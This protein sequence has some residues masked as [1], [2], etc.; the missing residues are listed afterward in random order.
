MCIFKTIFSEFSL[1]NIFCF[2]LV[3]IHLWFVLRNSLKYS[4]M[5]AN[6]NFQ[7]KKGKTNKKQKPTQKATSVEIVYK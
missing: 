1:W 6:V 5:P 4:Q 7:L 2:G 3:G